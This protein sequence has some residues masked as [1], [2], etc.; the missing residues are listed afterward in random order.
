[1]GI[2]DL[3]WLLTKKLPRQIGQGAREF[4]QERAPAL[5]RGRRKAALLCLGG[6]ALVVAAGL[7]LAAALQARARG[8]RTRALAVE[9]TES[10]RPL[11]LAPED[12]FLPE[13]PDAL[14]EFI[15]ARPRRE[16]WT[17][18]DAAEYWTDPL[19]GKE[20]LW[21]DRF[22]AGVDGLLEAVP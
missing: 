19:S 15:P 17:V 8:A 3:I 2:R 22:E 21:R 18:E 20:A 5:L 11:P 13:E 6:A 10:F 16:A 12:F 9:V 4:I 14:P 1:M 7:I